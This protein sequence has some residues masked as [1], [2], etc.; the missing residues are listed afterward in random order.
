LQQEINDYRPGDEVEVIV[1]RNGKKK[2]FDVKLRNMEGSTEIITGSETLEKLGA[3][4]ESLS[5]EEQ[6]RLGINHGVKVVRLKEGALKEAGIKEGFVVAYIDGNKV[7]SADD[8]KR[9][10]DQMPSG[11][12][13]EVE[14]LYPGS[15]MVY[16][17]QVELE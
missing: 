10:M 16:V 2:Q 11:A 14:G 8:I 9:I 17:Y 6:Q 15:N 13:I 3:E 1:K 12:R 4:F 7:N 5:R